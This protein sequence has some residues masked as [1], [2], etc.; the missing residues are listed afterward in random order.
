MKFGTVENLPFASTAVTSNGLT[1][2]LLSCDNRGSVSS[3]PTVSYDSFLENSTR[4]RVQLAEIQKRRSRTWRCNVNGE[5][6]K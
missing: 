4:E 2:W 1:F 5:A 6:K 3:M